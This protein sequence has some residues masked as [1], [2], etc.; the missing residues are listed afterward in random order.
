MP[1]EK[2]NEHRIISDEVHQIIAYKPK[3]IIR[4]G[5]ALFLI[6]IAGLLATTFFISYPDII[7]A[8]AK[9]TSVNAPK[10]V[11]VKAE[12]KLI[13]LNASEGRYVNENDIIGF[14]ES[15]A[16]H[17]EV[18]RLS[19]TIDSLQI[20][21]NDNLTE[22]VPGFLSNPCKHLGEIQPGYQVFM[23]GFNLFKQYLLSGYY[24]Q[25]KKMIS[26]DAM[27]LQK[28]HDNL[29]QQK[30]LQQEDVGLAK[31]TFE[32][33]K[34]LKE[35]KVISPLD[36]RNEQ[37]KFIGK[38]MSIP[39]IDLAIINNESS[40]HEKQKEIMELENNIAQQKDIFNQAVNTLKAQ[41]DEWKN[42]YLLIAPISGKIAFTGFLQENQLLKINQTVC[43]INPENSNYYAELYIPQ[44]NFG[45]T[46]AGQ[47][48]LLKLSSYPFQEFGA[49]KGRLEFIS[50]IP[51]DSGYLAK[52][53]LPNG[54]IT[55]YGKLVQYYEGLTASGEI[56]TSDLKLS[57]RLLNQLKSAIKNN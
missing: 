22:A 28:Q 32:A 2:E 43:F 7:P 45:K 30:K 57:D 38:A 23:Q 50:K 49:L 44:S 17:A 19:A 9:L 27:Y 39:Q 40:Q 15:R 1:L 35:E 4:N 41:L 8:R 52:V 18:I 53:V 31:E 33:N 34:T 6:I 11:K 5:I 55:T 21:M 3:W 56:I 51:T 12:G 16:D 37:S 29:L 13:K 24:L 54:L 10:E 26:G 25:K 14:M 48:V 36:Y 46:K 47:T 42:K 20:L